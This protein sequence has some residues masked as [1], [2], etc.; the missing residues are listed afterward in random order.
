MVGADV[1]VENFKTGGLAAKGLGWEDL[2][3]INPGLVYVSI[4]GFGQTGPRSQQP[5]YDY[6]AQSL[7]GLM[8]ITGRSDDEVG[9][10]PVRAGVAVADLSTGMYAT[11]ALSLIHI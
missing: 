10:G 6:L 8:S 9:G 2:R 1:F 7:G 11:V 4:T 5:G 3:K